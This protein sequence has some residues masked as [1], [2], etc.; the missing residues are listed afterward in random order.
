MINNKT[1]QPRCKGASRDVIN[2]YMD[3]VRMRASGEL[4]TTASWMRKFVLA[5]ADYKGDS[6]ISDTVRTCAPSC[7]S[8]KVCELCKQMSMPLG[9]TQT[10]VQASGCSR[11]CTPQRSRSDLGRERGTAA[12]TKL[13]AAAAAAPALLPLDGGASAVVV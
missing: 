9:S 5:H 6:K 8:K 13:A 1:N 12:Q 3:L 7:A 10:G 2:C 11:V 4:E